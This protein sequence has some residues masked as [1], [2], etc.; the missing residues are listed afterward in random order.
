MRGLYSPIDK[1]AAELPRTKGTG[2]EFMTELS[3]RPGYKPQ[4]AEDR[5]L[6]TLMAL[7][8]MERAKF[9]D[10]LKMKPAPKVEET[11]LADSILKNRGLNVDTD[12]P[13]KYEKHTLPGG[14]N[15]REILMHM[16]SHE[17]QHRKFNYPATLHWD[18]PA[19]LAHVRAKDRVGPNGEKLLHIEEI[20]SDWHQQGREH[21]YA[22]PEL[23]KEF[24]AAE[25]QHKGLRQQLE[26]AK[27]KSEYAEHSLGRKEPLF[28]QP[29]VRA[30]F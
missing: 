2:A 8:K 12:T 14:S 22:N 3:K 19:V 27:L 24:Q 11:T 7:P 5:N 15:Y 18:N 10:Q 21:G 13:T 17:G 6:Q 23:L 26:E 25:L 29:D 16:P 9:L 30:A 20:Q 4:E 1:L 28:Q